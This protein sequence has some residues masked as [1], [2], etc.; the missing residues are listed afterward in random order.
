[1]TAPTRRDVIA[2]AAIGTLARAGSRGL[3]HRAVDGA[4]GLP[5]GSTSYYLRS[6]ASLL[7]AIVDRLAVLDRGVVPEVQGAPVGGTGGFDAAEVLTQVVIEQLGPGRDRLVARYEL[8][9]EAVRRPDMQPALNAGKAAVR[10]R[11]SELLAGAGTPE[12]DVVA[13]D[14]LTLLD[15]LLFEEVTGAGPGRSAAQITALVRAMLLACGVP[16]GRAHPAGAADP[17][18]VAP[19]G[20]VAG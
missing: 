16:D 13:G 12:P 20:P 11:V 14:V 8:A 3:T 1:M 9:L 10:G 6:R 4:A 5:E 19:E 17:V 15:G 7:A 18:R 2:D